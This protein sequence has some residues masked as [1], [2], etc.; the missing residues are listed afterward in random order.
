MLA[1]VGVRL[2]AAGRQTNY[3][4]SVRVPFIEGT[5][6]LDE[7]SVA[8]PADGRPVNRTILGRVT[9]QPGS[10]TMTFTIDA[11]VTGTAAP[12]RIHQEVAVTVR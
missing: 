8:V 5:S 6:S 11:Y 2:H 4:G 10:Y 3:V 7:V 1:T 12:M 9:R